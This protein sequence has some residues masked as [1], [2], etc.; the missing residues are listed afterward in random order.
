MKLKFHINY[1]KSLLEHSHVFVYLVAI[2]AFPT[3]T[4]ELSVCDGKDRMDHKAED[5]YQTLK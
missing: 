3:T 1:E 5:I 4:A 2:V